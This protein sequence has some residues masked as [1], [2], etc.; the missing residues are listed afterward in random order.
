[1]FELFINLFCQQG[2]RLKTFE[3]QEMHYVANVSGR[4]RPKLAW[5]LL[6]EVVGVVHESWD[7]VQ[8][9][10]KILSRPVP[11]LSMSILDCSQACAVR[12]WHKIEKHHE[13]PATTPVHAA[14]ELLQRID[15]L[16]W[17]A[18]AEFECSTITS[19][20]FMVTTTVN[21]HKSWSI[22]IRNRLHIWTA[23]LWTTS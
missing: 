22:K 4:K 10:D 1:M 2:K 9:W 23:I 11:R 21:G 3:P 8:W 20:F 13:A 6:Y 19:D 18:N 15:L 14:K 5:R 16:T 17:R 7:L 12:L